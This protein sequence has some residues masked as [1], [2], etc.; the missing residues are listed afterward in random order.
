MKRLWLAVLLVVFASFTAQ[1]Q[2]LAKQQHDAWITFDSEVGRFTVLLP[3]TPGEKVETVQSN[4]GPY[5]THL[6][7]VRSK[8]TIFAVGW[9]DYDR[10]FIFGPQSELNAN[11]DNFIK[12]I[13]G[14]LVS[15]SYSIRDGYQSLEFTAETNDTIY[16]SRVVIVG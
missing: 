15:S 6:F 10:R 9:V 3:Q 7:S 2:E 12:G 1:S 13:K 4:V 16:T 5:T 14:T 11:R 8:G